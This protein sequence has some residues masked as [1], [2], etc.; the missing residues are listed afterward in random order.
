MRCSEGQRGY[1]EKEGADPGQ[2]NL[3]AVEVGVESQSAAQVAGPPVEA[4]HG[5]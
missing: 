1:G 5:Q 3:G 2:V 4:K